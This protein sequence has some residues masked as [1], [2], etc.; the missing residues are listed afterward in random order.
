MASSLS[1]IA[2]TENRRTIEI[3]ER[4]LP[5]QVIETNSPIVSWHWLGSR[6]TETI[7]QNL[8]IDS[9]HPSW[10]DKH[11]RKPTAALLVQLTLASSRTHLNDSQLTSTVAVS[12]VLARPFWSLSGAPLG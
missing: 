8:C 6:S 12:S 7:C 9:V 1:P 3:G 5:I 4:C 2:F 11:G 10:I